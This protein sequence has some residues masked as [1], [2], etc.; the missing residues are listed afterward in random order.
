M[1]AFNSFIQAKKSLIFDRECYG[2]IGVVQHGHYSIT[3]HSVQNK[4]CNE[5]KAL[6][7]A[8]K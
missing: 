3:K 8:S 5:R 6:K 7:A 1:A 2:V 4:Q